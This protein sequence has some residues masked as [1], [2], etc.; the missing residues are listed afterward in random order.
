MVCRFDTLEV[1]DPAGTPVS[2]MTVGVMRSV[3][4]GELK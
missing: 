1:V 2:R 3:E 4:M